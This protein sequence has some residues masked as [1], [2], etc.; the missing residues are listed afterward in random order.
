MTYS[1]I[2]HILQQPYSLQNFKALIDDIFPQTGKYLETLLLFEESER[3]SKGFQFG[4][5]SLADG[6]SIALFDI[7]VA[8]SINITKNRK[9]LRDIAIK[10]IDNGIINGALVAFHS[11]NK[12]D[13]RLSFMAKQ[14]GFTDEGEFVSS[15]TAPK[16]YTFMLGQ[17]ESCTTAA[18]R[19]SELKEKA[20]SVGLGAIIEAFSVEKL[21]KDFFKG[22]KEHYEKFWKY[23][24][25]QA[26]YRKL[27][28]DAE[29]ATQEKQEKPIRDFAKKL[30]G[31]IVFLYFLQKKGWM[32][33]PADRSDW[34]GG[35]PNFIKNLFIDFSDKTQ[36][37]SQ[38][39]TKLFF[40]TLNNKRPNDIFEIPPLG[41]RG[42]VPYLNGGLFDNDL[43]ETNHFDFPESYFAELFDFFDQFNFTI[44]E[45]DPD[46]ANVGIDP[47]MLGHIFENLLEE[48]KDKG[49]FYTPKAIVQY[50]CQESLIQYL[51]THLN[52]LTPDGGTGTEA[53]Q[54]FIRN[55]DRGKP[56]GFITQ[57]AKKME[58][59]L[60]NVKICDPA[61]GS[62]AFPMGMLNEIFKAKMTLDLTLDP[63]EVKR[64]IIQNSIYGVDLE[65]GAV[66]IARLRFWLALVV[67]EDAPSPLPNLDY[68]I[69][70]GNSLLESFEGIPLSNLQQTKTAITLIE[71]G[72]QLD[73]FGNV[74]AQQTRMEFLDT[75]RQDL[76][77]LIDTYFDADSQHKT[78]IKSQINEIVHDHL[79]YNVDLKLAEIQTKLGEIEAEIS[80]ITIYE[81]DNKAKREQKQKALA[82]KQKALEKLQKEEERL[83][84]ALTTLDR[85]QET[86]ER[87]YFLWHLFFKDVFERGGFD[88]VIGNPPYIQ[89]QKDSGYLAKLFEN[90]GFETFERT[91]DIYSLFYEKGFQLLK[92]KGIHTFITSS[93]W[94]KAGYG[95]SLRKYF[96]SQNPLLLLALGP[97]VFEN[98][99]V[100]TNILVAQKG[101]FANLLRGSIISKRTEIE[102]QSFKIVEMPY[103]NTETWVIMNST[104]QTLWQ[105]LKLKG[106]SLNKW[107][108]NIYFGVKTGYN[109]AF[110]IDENTRQELI[111]QDSKNDEIIKPILR[112]REIEKYL[113]EWDGGYLI[114]TFPAFNLDISE[115]NGVARYLTSFGKRLYQVGETFINSNGEIIKTRK[116]TGNK[117]FETQDQIGFYKEF[118]KEKIIWKRIGSQLRFSYSDEE[119]YCLDSTCIATGEKMKYLTALLNSK[120]THYQLFE[121]SPRTGMGDLIISVQALEPLLIYYPTEKEEIQIET[122]VNQILIDKKDGKDTATLEAEIDRLVY[123]LYELTEAEIA[124]V[125]G[126]V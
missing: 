15:Q 6:K 56:K 59:L 71:G 40:E 1:E 70:Q 42:L 100:D 14:A 43:P 62:G 24:N 68:K 25:T 93:Q 28:I 13:Y 114:S 20:P 67:D 11:P 76:D 118:S 37:Y 16:R 83:Q 121:N 80:L 79:H 7:E 99:T 55:G 35:D 61:I 74:V 32:G 116:K 107:D 92:N 87:P 22:Y 8:E 54:A 111:N 65:R 123:E 106:K 63:A 77:E 23:I 98:A 82:T 34:Q 39:L 113:T 103:V 73:M 31:R 21:N 12:A 96:I 47:E 49:A 75:K 109:E 41:L 60:D 4:N 125:E 94:M 108:V 53:I 89:L 18:K 120:L 27:L 44:D 48:N 104:K 101:E 3:V 36:F 85:I 17:N 30:L 46:D 38:V 10:Y 78:K 84:N 51:S 119:M 9:G 5:I 26:D 115:Y 69:M 57:N 117:W 110:L 102:N 29:Q 2:K 64:H 45:N 95:A 33:V 126:K 66:D 88:I 50:M 72:Q 58:E 52:P 91:G 90:E 97:N 112:G 86:N 81:N 19:L 124:I 105:K 122:L